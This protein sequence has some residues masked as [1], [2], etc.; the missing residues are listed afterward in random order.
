MASIRI[1]LTGG[2]SGGHLFPLLSV[3]ESIRKK[4]RGDVEFLFIGPGG[5]FG[6]EAMERAG[7]STKKIL[8]GKM[9]RYFSFANLTDPLK[10]PIGVIQSLWHLLWFMPDAVFSK[11]GSGSVPVVIAARIYRIP[12]MLHDSDA[13]A[14]RANRFLATFANRIAVAYPSAKEFFPS[15]KTALTGNP[16]RSDVLGGDTI[17]GKERFTLPSEK[18]ILFVV[19]GSLGAQFLNESIV[20]ILPK[21]LEVASVIHQTGEANFASTVENA[22]I[23]GVSPDDEKGYRPRKFLSAEEIGDALASA[24]LVIS[25]AG[26]GSIAEIAAYGKAAILVPLASAAND[27]QRMN[28]YDVA[29]IG[30][31]FVLEEGNLTEHIF[32]SKIQELLSNESVRKEMGEKLKV[33]YHADA[34]DD[35]ANG[36]FSMIG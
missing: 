16:V 23:F 17:R 19:G 1:V 11:G 13:V 33:F 7:I 8:S 4:A 30:G 24:D 15:K 36:I 21:I 22:K 14:G 2:V 9:R 3:A 31:A 28:A 5:S 26:A 25:R 29:A 35:I 20:K 12:V 27:E 34:A 10:V 18:P 6:S 32:L